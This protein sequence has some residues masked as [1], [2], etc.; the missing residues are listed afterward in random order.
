[1]NKL[2]DEQIAKM[3]EEA[4]NWMRAM[5]VK[6]EVISDFCQEDKLHKVYV[7]H[8]EQSIM[9]EELSRGELRKIK[10]VEERYNVLVYYVIRDEAM[11]QD[12]TVF[13]RYTYLYITSYEEDWEMYRNG[14]KET[15][16]IP[17]YVQNADEPACSELTEISFRC[18]KGV[19]INAS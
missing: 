16:C 5:R 3:K 15:K 10:E 4:G 9:E 6:E 19:L 7:N 13:S 8:D 18:I 1:M 17:A 14:I 2:T 11:W 12:G